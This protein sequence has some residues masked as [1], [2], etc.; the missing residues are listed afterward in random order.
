MKKILNGKVIVVTGSGRGVGR[1]VAIEAA[2]NGARVVVNDI[3]VS[4]T[5][6]EDGVDPTAEVVSEIKKMGGEAVAN[7]DSVATWKSAQKIIQC[8][9]DNFGR[10]DGIV[11]NAGIL[12][13]ILFHKMDPEDF[14][15]VID[16]NLRGPFYVSRAAA[17]YFREQQSGSFVHM[18]STAALIGNF[19]QVNYAASKLGLVG[20]SNS[21]AIDMQKFGVNSNCIAPF[22][23][24]RMVQTIPANSPEAVARLEGLKRLVPERIAPFAVALMSDE[25]RARVTSQIFGVRN[26][27]IYLFGK[28]R[29]INTMHTSD[30]WTPDAVVDRVFPAF[31]ANF[32]PPM[33]SRDVFTWDPV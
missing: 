13:D 11:N 2:R 18:T 5:G 1:G 15:R 20:M 23:W 8:A 28:N 4:A 32:L 19:G 31:E 17:P 9:L 24:T 29:P 30:G 3:G 33:T 6:E 14:D 25:G 21:I 27:E 10:I 22:A 26:N 12:R 7:T 16:V